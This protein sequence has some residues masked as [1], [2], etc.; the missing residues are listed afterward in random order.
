[1]ICCLVTN[2]P[3]RTSFVSEATAADEPSGISP[4]R[5]SSERTACCPDTGPVETRSSGHRPIQA[6]G[7]T[8]DKL[9]HEPDVEV[10][11][12]GD[13]CDALA[14]ARSARICATET[15]VP[16]RTGA[17]PCP[18]STRCSAVAE[19]SRRKLGPFRQPLLADWCRDRRGI[20]NARH[21]FSFQTGRN[22]FLRVPSPAGRGPGSYFGS[23][24]QYVYPAGKAAAIIDAVRPGP[25][26][27]PGNCGAAKPPE[28]GQARKLLAPPG[29]G[30]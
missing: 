2:L 15:R 21:V 8:L 17:P 22:D 20:R 7:K 5:H 23:G 30:A 28:T 27:R 14:F 4:G 10:E 12:L 24:C 9:L 25:S 1:V 16:L 3:R 29:L 19:L 6:H 13:L 26:C 11:V 18:R